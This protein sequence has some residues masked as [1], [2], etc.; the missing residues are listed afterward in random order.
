MIVTLFFPIFRL[1]NLQQDTYIKLSAIKYI[2]QK[3]FLK[4]KEEFF[5]TCW[6]LLFLGLK[7]LM[8]TQ[9]SYVIL[10]LKKGNL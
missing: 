5:I 7:L 4:N 1:L 9:Y 10:T 3:R 6:K 8:F 2:Y